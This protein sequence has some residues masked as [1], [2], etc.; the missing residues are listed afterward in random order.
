MTHNGN[1]G[2]GARSRV[3]NGLI[4]GLLGGLLGAL[5]LACGCGAGGQ[6]TSPPKS[7]G[8]AS[9]NVNTYFG[10]DPVASPGTV[11]VSINHTL[12][13][14]SYRKRANDGTFSPAGLTSGSLTPTSRGFLQ[15][16][17]SVVNGM[18][19]G[20]PP[21]PGWAV[22]IPGWAGVARFGNATT[23]QMVPIA[24]TDRCPA[25][26]TTSFIFVTLLGTANPTPL[27]N[28]ATDTAFGAVDIATNQ[29]DV[30]FS[31]IMQFR[32]AG[33]APS[34]PGMDTAMGGC[35]ETSVLGNLT[36]VPATGVPAGM[37]P[38]YVGV[39]AD[40]LLLE[41]NGAPTVTP[42][43]LLGSG[44]GAIGV[45]K[46]ADPVDATDVVKKQYLG[47]LVLRLG[48]NFNSST[49][50]FGCQ[51]PSGC[52]VPPASPTAMK[53]GTFA[54]DNPAGALYGAS[55]YTLELGSQDPANNGL[56][57][58]A[59]LT[60]GS[61]VYSAVVVVGRIQGRYVIFL[62]ANRGPATNPIALYLFQDAG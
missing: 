23:A 54:S 55:D 39:Q 36:S 38:A 56:F 61:N 47:F 41:N 49:A 8:G 3:A 28:P 22:E 52:P 10:S 53:G 6:I 21:P 26:P 19:Q 60:Q 35:S 43:N 51:A 7:P 5:A 17:F 15:M 32:L 25:F 46:P 18:P 12:N 33:T 1:R 11:A 42:S 34:N 50:S 44:S 37:S 14:A 2:R 58:S 31:N 13:E 40:G 29:A 48:T 27:W 30:S 9:Q 24:P 62:I 16:T 20:T 4:T 59:R 45:A 57:R